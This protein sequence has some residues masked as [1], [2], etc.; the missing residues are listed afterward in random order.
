MFA[1]DGAAP[2]VSMDEL[3][4]AA[5][6]SAGLLI[7]GMGIVRMAPGLAAWLPRMP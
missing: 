2:D 3:F 1:F 5:W 4:A 7:L 6:P